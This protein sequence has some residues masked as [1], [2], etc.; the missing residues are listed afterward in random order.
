MGQWQVIVGIVALC[1]TPWAIVAWIARRIIRGDLIPRAA[2]LDRVGD[3]R[4]TITALEDTVAE[5]DRQ[6]GILLGKPVS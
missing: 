1:G 4:A 2:H 5:K 6:I 3:L